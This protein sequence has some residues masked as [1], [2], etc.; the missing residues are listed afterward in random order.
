MKIAFI[1][2]YPKS[3]APSQRFRLEHYLQTLTEK[4]ISFDYF[5]F[6]R[7]KDFEILYNKGLYF[8]KISAV[9]LG[10]LKRFLL[11]FTI[12]KY[13]YVYVLREASPIGPPF[14]EFV[15]AKIL[16]KKLIYDFD[17][18]I[19]LANTSGNNKIVA[20]IKWH[21]KVE[22]I[23]KWSYKV[24]VGNQFLKNY[25]LQFNS[26]VHIVP[27]VV[28]TSTKHNQI[29]NQNTDKPNIGWTGTHSTMVY[30]EEILPVIEKLEKKYDFNFVVISNKKPDWHLTSLQ[31]ISWSAE[32][33]IEDLLRF[34]IGIM[35]LK[36]DKW[37]EGKCGFK[38]IQYMALGIP[39]I[40]SP[41]GVNTEIVADTVD[42]LVAETAEEWYEC[43]EKLIVDKDLRLQYAR[44]ARTKIEENYSVMSSKQDFL[45][46][47]L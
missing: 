10:F 44:K 33:E 30:L 26:N 40:V 11:L 13:D 4:G 5:S 39:A 45:N 1:V 29:Q 47:F 46:L 24:S 12:S 36:K 34:H 2:P 42:G 15:V 23:C 31:Y 43:L 19:W 8:Q 17:D 38:A 35:P 20:N 27:T 14:F 9:L 37:S 25:A 22:S 7:K 3:T 18:S 32:S 41:I 28:N 6:L 21:H 16:R